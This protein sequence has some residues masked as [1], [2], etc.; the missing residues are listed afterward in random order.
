MTEVL[1]LDAIANAERL[2]EYYKTTGK[3]IGPLHGVPMSVKDQ[4]DV[5]GV[6]TTLGYVG[7]ASKPAFEDAS[8]VKVLKRLGAVILTKTNVPQSILV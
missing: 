2:D 7:R 8:L 4:F 6:D 3:L 1:F 5:V